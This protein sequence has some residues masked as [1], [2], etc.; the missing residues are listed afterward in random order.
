[1]WP[2]LLA[3]TATTVIVFL[4]VIFMKNTEG[5][6]FADLALTI[7]GRDRRVAGHGDDGSAGG[8]GALAS[9]GSAGAADRRL[10]G[11]AGDPA[12]WC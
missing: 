9:A 1:M 5:Q 8:G 7:V 4:P 2:A 10:A 12:W 3:S 6:L 11:A